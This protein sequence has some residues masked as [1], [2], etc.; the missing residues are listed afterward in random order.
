M[1]EIDAIPNRDTLSS[2]VQRAHENAIS[3]GRKSRQ[4]RWANCESYVAEVFGR[5]VED[6]DAL[7]DVKTK[8]GTEQRLI[9]NSEWAYFR[10][11]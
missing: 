9:E 3:F 6:E 10:R 7:E 5:Q 8:S 2:S 1:F 11:C 4:H